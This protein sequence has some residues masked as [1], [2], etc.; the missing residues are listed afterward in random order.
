MSGWFFLLPFDYRVVGKEIAASAVFIT[1][2]VLWQERGYFD[3]AAE[4][5]PLLHLWSLGVEEQFYIFWPLLMIATWRNRHGPLTAAIAIFIVS[6]TLNIILTR[7][8]EVAAFYLPITRF[9]ELMAGCI[10]AIVQS[11]NVDLSLSSLYSYLR[12]YPLLRLHQRLMLLYSRLGVPIS[13][14]REAAASAGL[15]LIV[16]ALALINQKVSFPGWWA[17]MPVVGAGL[18]IGSGSSTW[19]SRRILG[20]PVLVYVGLI[21]YP[22]YLWHWPLLVLVRIVDVGEPAALTKMLGIA[23]AFLFA[24]V[25]YH[26]VE[27]PIRFS[28]VPRSWW[29]PASATMAAIGVLGLAIYATDGVPARYR[30][31]LQNSLKDYSEE[32]MTAYNQD[33]CF[34]GEGAEFSWFRKV[35][36]GSSTSPLRYKILV[37][38]D[39]HAAH[40]MPGLRAVMAS[41]EQTF[42]LA[43]FTTS[44]CP[45][46][47]STS[48]G[49]QKNCVSINDSILKVIERLKP[50]TVVMAGFWSAYYRS[51]DLEMLDAAIQTT[52]ARIRSTGVRQIV[53]VGQFPIWLSPPPRILSQIISSTS[54]ENGQNLDLLKH[55]LAM[56]NGH[57]RSINTEV[58]KAFLTAGA[59]FISPISS[60]CSEIGCLLVVPHSGGV[61]IGWDTAHLTV[62]G[63]AYFATENAAV[64]F[65]H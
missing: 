19:I 26:F 10:L 42:D 15:L 4:L 12:L 5:K 38:G 34:L 1:N 53:G 50:E 20:Q 58:G 21:S 40:L 32:S 29:A 59:R 36:E 44:S 48:I 24:I 13:A 9:W 65:A 55:N 57:A 33:G 2:I 11:S 49:P 16:L 41:Q 60:L 28:Q 31:D 51:S 64:F 43:Q 18:L 25:T 35:C 47:L 27:K 46:L 22:L 54:G 17:L 6:L 30:A 39:S 23:G 56:Q 52:V 62:S 7:T 8:D 63:S 45:P 37:W 61:P 14:M 3:T